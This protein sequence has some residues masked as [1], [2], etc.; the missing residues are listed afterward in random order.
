M[1]ALIVGAGG[2]VGPH[3]CRHLRDDLGWC[4]WATKLPHERACADADAVIDLDVTNADAVGEA[5]G[6]ARADVI[7]HLAAQ[8]SV[9]LSWENPGLTVDVN[10]KGTLN[11][12]EA[13]RAQANKTRAVLI[14]S[15]EEYGFVAPHEV[16]VGEQTPLR[17][18]NP[19]ALTKAAQTMAG[20]VYARAY[21]VD[22]V[23]V[24][25]F[26]HIG[27]LQAP[28]FVVSDFCRQVAEMET[29]RRAPVL[30]VGNL[31][32]ERDFTDVRDVVRAYALL[33][34][35]GAGGEVYNVGTGTAHS[36]QTVLDLILAQSAVAVRVEVDAARF[37]PA[38]VP[39][40]AADI[41]K[42]RRDT[43]FAP[44]IPLSQSVADTLGYWREQIGRE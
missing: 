4:V 9:A 18:G 20:Q 31:T 22:A 26:N 17:P 23:M 29:G 38:D 42:L 1:K 33:A 35:R 2:F 8:S 40:L 12:L 37:R 25:A 19:Y 16:P 13:L 27:P 39:V 7:F 34:A 6:R 3:L 10:I 11:L 32:A 14:G 44:A 36:I 24:R 15:G 5:L 41:T 43:G 28:Q 21:G 30:R